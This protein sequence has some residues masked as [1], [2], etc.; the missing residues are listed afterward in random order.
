MDKFFSFF[1]DSKFYV[2]D[3]C[4]KVFGN[5]CLSF[6]SD[7]MDGNYSKS[8]FLNSQKGVNK[9]I[10]SLHTNLSSEI[11]ASIEH[12]TKKYIRL[13]N[14]EFGFHEINIDPVINHINSL[15]NVFVSK[16]CKDIKDFINSE[17]LQLKSYDLN[18]IDFLYEKFSLNE[19]GMFY[20][21]LRTM[22]H[23]NL[24]RSFALS[25]LFINE[26]FDMKN[27]I[28]SNSELTNKKVSDSGE[29]FQ[30]FKKELKKINQKNILFKWNKQKRTYEGYPPSYFGVTEFVFPTR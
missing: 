17:L 15:L 16:F 18:S 13:Y 21:K 5:F 2:Y 26:H 10:K 19:T 30:I 8:L 27:I 7:L 28:V 1:K 14:K 20:G 9:K 6:F 11:S 25:S 24:I 3:R 4:K 23:M 29:Y 22:V 12:E